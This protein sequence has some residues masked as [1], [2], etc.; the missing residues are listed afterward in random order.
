[1]KLSTLFQRCLEAPYVHLAESA[2]CCFEQQ[3]ET[4]Y[5]YLQDSDGYEDWKNNLDF[6]ARPYRR[7]GQT[8]WYAH[9]GFVKVWRAVEPYIASAVMEESVRRVVT[10]GYSHGGALAVLCHEYIWFHRPDLRE[11]I[12]GYGF[13]AP[14]VIWGVYGQ[15]ISARW[16]RFIVVRN[17]D[18]IVTH[19]PPRSL[20]Y[21]HVGRLVEVGEK[22]KYS[23]IDAHRSENILI[24]LE[25]AKM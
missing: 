5:I 13:G 1:M 2:D 12:E 21:F 17:I 8:H 25:R 7:M 24:E 14:R 4:L 16:E 10:V 11:H 15:D 6:P 3:G 18:D 20:G 9:R 23:R 19:L 22:G